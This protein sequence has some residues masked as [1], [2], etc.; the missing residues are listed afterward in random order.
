MEIS[1]HVKEGALGA[2]NLPRMLNRNWKKQAI[3]KGGK[4]AQKEGMVSI[5][6]NS[7]KHINL[8]K[9]I[10]VNV[11]NFGPKEGAVSKLMNNYKSIKSRKLMRVKA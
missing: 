11:G 9:E 6:M 10:R 2:S 3:R 7:Y 8:G 5:L 4:L 1:F